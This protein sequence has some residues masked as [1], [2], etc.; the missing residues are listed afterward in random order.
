MTVGYIPFAVMTVTS[1]A[2]TREGGIPGRAFGANPEPIN[3]NDAERDVTRLALSY[4]V[5][6]LGFHAFGAV[7][8]VGLAC[9]A[10]E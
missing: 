8:R 9:G 10:P 1:T 6:A 7:L 2:M 4:D 5:A 3:T